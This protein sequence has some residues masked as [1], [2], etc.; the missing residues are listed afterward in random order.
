MH[1]NHQVEKQRMELEEQRNLNGGDHK[2][3]ERKLLML[4]EEEQKMHR[5][6]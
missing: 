5:K 3:I 2:D 4:E 6:M 1:V